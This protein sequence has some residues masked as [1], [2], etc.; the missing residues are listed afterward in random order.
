MRVHGPGLRFH[1][2]LS[3]F[4]CKG[5]SEIRLLLL[6]VM[7][8]GLDYLFTRDAV[9]NDTNASAI[10][11]SQQIK[12]LALAFIEMTRNGNRPAKISLV[13]FRIKADVQPY[14]FARPHPAIQMVIINKR[15]EESWIE[16]IRA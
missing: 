1:Q 8:A 15:F 11:T 10:S 14:E 16:R 12:S 7:N 6:D 5:G 2:N 4:F 13:H 9:A 3:R